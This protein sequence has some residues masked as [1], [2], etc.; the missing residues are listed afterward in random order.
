M[1]NVFPQ[2]GQFDEVKSDAIFLLY[3][4]KKNIKVNLAYSFVR[5]L[6]G[7]KRNIGYGMVLTKV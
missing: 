2:G 5:N 7:G 3:A 4:L 1:H 6:M